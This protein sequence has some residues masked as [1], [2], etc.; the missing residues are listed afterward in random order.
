MGMRPLGAVSAG[1]DFS[2]VGCAGEASVG[3][4]VTDIWCALVDLGRQGVLFGPEGNDC[5]FLRFVLEAA[6]RHG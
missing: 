2:K 5:G 1:A 6:A 3:A 4:R